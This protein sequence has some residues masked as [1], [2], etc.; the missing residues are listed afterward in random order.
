MNNIVHIEVHCDDK[1]NITAIAV[2][3]KHFGERIEPHAFV[4]TV[5]EAFYKT[6]L[7]SDVGKSLKTEL[8]A[9]RHDVVDLIITLKRNDLKQTDVGNFIEAFQNALDKTKLF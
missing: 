5:S 6:T 1:R 4:A 2:K 7:L 8:N 3:V 9:K